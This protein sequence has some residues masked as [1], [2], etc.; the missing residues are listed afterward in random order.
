MTDGYVK[1]EIVRELIDLMWK[2]DGYFV[3]LGYPVDQEGRYR[4]R[5]IVKQVGMWPKEEENASARRTK[6]KSDRQTETQSA[7]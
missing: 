6:I 1:K 5:D 7:T 4:F 3:G 2:W